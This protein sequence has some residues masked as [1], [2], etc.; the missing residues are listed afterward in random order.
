[1]GSARLDPALAHRDRAAHGF[2]HPGELNV[3]LGTRASNALD[4]HR[5]AAEHSR[6]EEI[7]GRGGIALDLD[8]AGRHVAAVGRHH[9]GAPAFA[10]DVDAE[11]PHEAQGELDVRLRD[12]L[13]LDL[14]HRALSRPPEG[15]EER[16]QELARHVAAHA[17]AIPAR[18]VSRADSERGVAGSA[19]ILDRRSRAPQRRH[20]V[21][22][23]TLVHAR[24]AGELVVPVGERE[25]RGERPEGRARV[26]EEKAGA[27]A[28]K[29]ARRAEPMHAQVLDAV[30]ALDPNA[31]GLQRLAHHARVVGIEERVK[32][33]SAARKRSEKQRAVGDALGAGKPEAPRCARRTRK[34]QVLHDYSFEEPRRDPA[35]RDWRLARAS[36][37]RR[38]SP[39][40]SPLSTSSRNTASCAP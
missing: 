36:A 18:G 31:E 1:M 28:G 15:H 6:G 24:D 23:G 14:D 5:P 8:D 34:V 25:H 33:G 32:L 29:P 13:A 3:A 39:G 19:A 22:D 40:P 12:E 10:L 9:E 37:M 38:S 35:P 16:G 27:L 21:A 4:A 30:E 17:H 2:E 26:T 11:A 20:Q 7:R